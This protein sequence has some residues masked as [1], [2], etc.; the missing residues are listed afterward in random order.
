M[1]VWINSRR[2]Y[3]QQQQQQQQNC[4]IKNV[5]FPTCAARGVLR[6]KNAAKPRTLR[7]N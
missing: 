5:L 6:E 3:V 2:F 7:P 4:F 1:K